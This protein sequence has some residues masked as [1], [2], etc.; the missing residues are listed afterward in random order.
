MFFAGRKHGSQD[1]VGTGGRIPTHH[2][3]AVMNGAPA[4]LLDSRYIPRA[5]TAAQ[6]KT[7]ARPAF[8]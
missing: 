3:K 7:P 8:P 2:D 6:E 4:L 5:V 1:E